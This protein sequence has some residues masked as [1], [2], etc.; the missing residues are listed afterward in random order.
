MG[1][2]NAG[3][4]KLG[5]FPLFFFLKM[6]FL[7]LTLEQKLVTA[8]QQNKVRFACKGR[9]H[10]WDRMDPASAQAAAT[11]AGGVPAPG[12]GNSSGDWLPRRAAG[13]AVEPLV[14]K[15]PDPWL[16]EEEG[17]H[18]APAGSLGCS[19]RLLPASKGPLLG[20]QR[21]DSG[22]GLVSPE[23]PQKHLD[24]RNG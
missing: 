11:E 2:R 12:A 7:E 8:F 13:G 19:L 3:R 21:K 18:C 20:A 9:T 22:F 1:Y 23:S 6:E 14:P 17:A 4:Q 16:G 15:F 5:Y 24:T 10:E